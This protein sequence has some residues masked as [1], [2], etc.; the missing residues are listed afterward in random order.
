MGWRGAWTGL[1]WIAQDR[2]K[3]QTLA[4]IVMNY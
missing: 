2:D 3:W 1:I 4:K